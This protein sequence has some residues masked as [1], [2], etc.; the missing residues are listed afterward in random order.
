V[1]ATRKREGR[2]HSSAA[3]DS[4]HLTASNSPTRLLSPLAGGRAQVV[5]HL[6]RSGHRC[7]KT[8]NSR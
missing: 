1:Q 3:H 4:Q 2:S 7:H 6:G 8:S 5:A